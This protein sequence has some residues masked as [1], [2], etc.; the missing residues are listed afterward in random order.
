M[1][2]KKIIDLIKEAILDIKH[3]GQDIVSID[4]L[5]NYLDALKGNTEEIHKADQQ[6][7]ELNFRAEHERNLA[8]YDAQQQ[9][10]L[11]MLR[12]VISYSQAALKSAILI[13]GGAAVAL[14]AFIGNIWAKTTAKEAVEFLT[15]SIASFSFGVLAAAFG[16]G[17]TYLTQYCYM[18]S[19]NKTAIALH[20]LTVIVV[21]ISFVLFANG[22]YEAYLAFFKHLTP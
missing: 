8:H 16:A 14:L 17:T 1:Q 9:Y 4:A 5:L 15:F 10:S 21:L 12:S 3:K 11:E 22:A 7:F 13:N 19:W 18:V 20:I 2:A 6:K